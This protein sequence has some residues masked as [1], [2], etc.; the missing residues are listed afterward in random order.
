[1]EVPKIC[2]KCNQPGEFRKRKNGRDGLNSTCKRCE[3][4]SRKK[5][6]ANNT[7]KFKGY[8]RGWQKRNP[9]Q[10]RAIKRSWSLNAL[11]GLSTQDFLLLLTSQDNRCAICHQEFD[12]TRSPFV[13]HNHEMAEVDKKLSVRGLLCCKCNF[14][15]GMAGESITTLKALCEYLVIPIPEY[16]P[17]YGLSRPKAAER[18]YREGLRES[19]GHGCMACRV[20]L[21]GRGKSKECIDHDHTTGKIRGILCHR[22]NLVLGHFDDNSARILSAIQYLDMWG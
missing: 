10:H 11:Y 6:Y 19:C 22:C 13:D 2:T 14:G 18:L 8:I 17:V 4:V 16:A 12:D 1:M 5:W 3:Q 20:P 21:S 9:Q 7:D 15:V